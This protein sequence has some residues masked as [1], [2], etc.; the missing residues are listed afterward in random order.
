MGG[1]L[2]MMKISIHDGTGGRF[3]EALS[4]V[5]IQVSS[6]VVKFLLRILVLH[7]FGL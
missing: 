5:S 7:Q 6:S 1:I 3:I 2:K 4:A